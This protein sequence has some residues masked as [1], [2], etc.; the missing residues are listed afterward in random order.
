[1][2]QYP[3]SVVGFFD[4]SGFSSLARDLEQADKTRSEKAI[5]KRSASSYFAQHS[6]S[7]K[8][9]EELVRQLNETLSALIETIRA[10]GGDII[11]FAGDAI[12][13]VW[14]CDRDTM[15]CQ[16]LRATKC[17]VDCTMLKS[18]QSKLG[19]HVGIGC[20]E[21]V[22]AHVG[23]TFGR[24]EF[25]IAGEA[26]TQ[27]ALSEGHAGVNE[28]V[29]SPQ[30]CKVIHDSKLAKSIKGDSLEEGF[31]L[32]KHLAMN[33]P[34]QPPPPK[35]TLSTDPDIAKMAEGF[36][37]GPVRD[38]LKSGCSSSSSVGGL[39]KLTVIFF[40]LHDVVLPEKFDSESELKFLEQCQN[41]AKLVQDSAYHYW[42]T[43]RQFILDDKGFVAIVALGLP[44]YFHEDNAV[45]AVKVAKRLIEHHKVR[46]AAGICTG[47][48]FCG[49]VGST[50]RAEYSVAGSCI[51]LAARLM[52]RAKPGQIWCDTVT[53][54]EAESLGHI[55]FDQFPS[56][57]FKGFDQPVDIFG[58]SMA[59]ASSSNAT[60]PEAEE[61]LTKSVNVHTRL[62]RD[63]SAFSRRRKFTRAQS[64]RLN[65]N[66]V[67]METELIALS[68]ASFIGKDST[69]AVFLEGEAGSGKTRLVEWVLK[70][71][72]ARRVVLSAADSSEINT[73]FFV[74]R[75]ILQSVLAFTKSV[76][77]N[78][79]IPPTKKLPIGEKRIERPLAGRKRGFSNEADSVQSHQRRLSSEQLLANLLQHGHKR[80]Q[81]DMSKH[82]LGIASTVFD[83]QVPQVIDEGKNVSSELDE[84]EGEE[85]DALLVAKPPSG[86]GMS[87]MTAESL[88]TSGPSPKVMSF[89]YQSQGQYLPDQSAVLENLHESGKLK[90]KR[91]S[92]LHTILPTL[93]LPS[94]LENGQTTPT[95][96]AQLVFGSAQR[97]ASLGNRSMSGLN[98]SNINSSGQT[99][100]GSVALS[101]RTDGQSEAQAPMD[102]MLLLLEEFG[103]LVTTQIV[104]ENAH[105]MD[106][107][108]WELVKRLCEFSP[109]SWKGEDRIRI[110]VTYRPF[111]T[112]RDHP[113][114]MLVHGHPAASGNLSMARTS[115]DIQPTSNQALGGAVPGSPA[116]G[117]SDKLSSPPRVI[118]S[119]GARRRSLEARNPTSTV[120]VALESRSDSEDAEPRVVRVVISPFSQREAGVFLSNVHHT[121]MGPKLLSFLFRKS[122]GNPRALLDCFSALKD[123]EL[124][125]LDTATG[126]VEETTSLEDI[127]DMVFVIPPHLRAQLQQQFDNLHNREQ[128]ILKL[129]S[130]VGSTIPISLLKWLYKE[131]VTHMASPPNDASRDDSVSL[132]SDFNQ[133][134]L[135][136]RERDFLHPFLQTIPENARDSTDVGILSGRIG[137]D[138]EN[139]VF[140]S[141]FVQF[142]VYSQMLHT[143]RREVHGLVLDWYQVSP[144]HFR[145]REDPSLLGNH[146]VG[147][148]RH[149]TAFQCFQ[150]GLRR[151]VFKHEPVAKGVRL[152]QSCTD[153][154]DDPLTGFDT[155]QTIAHRVA[156]DVLMG[157]VCVQNE[158][159]DE[160]NE[161][162]QRAIEYAD[163]VSPRA[164][165]MSCFP[166]IWRRTRQRM[167]DGADKDPLVSVK[168]N[169][170]AEMSQKSRFAVELI[171]RIE[172]CRTVY[173]SR[174]ASMKAF[175][176]QQVG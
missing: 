66:L 8:G 94:E 105:F 85:A 103:I 133:G 106:K 150:E 107:Q 93:V 83:V 37:P 53:K 84:D 114:Q 102:M 158:E 126:T 135:E 144:P 68:R 20:G 28:V 146:A 153:L 71:S 72:G 159:W 82:Q 81:S 88:S 65:V 174:V 160:A 130:V 77:Q 22:A 73:P 87:F 80:S 175:N 31:F 98:S 52:A 139:W 30:A 40:K 164:E 110:V 36:V 26:C 162:L 74:W 123:Q 19:L 108:S 122:K 173:A 47:T 27:S 16:L 129:A 143:A 11:K 111:H 78:T 55:R 32:I 43:L 25:F 41:Q 138:D 125:N 46:A 152:W 128:H 3:E 7:G 59:T 169:L 140:E 134:L 171:R 90:G 38:A 35:Y 165:A 34:G 54:T 172:E 127:G 13:V 155:Q 29:V 101:D 137:C 132:D 49:V 89:M 118:M 124:I 116:T 57:P 96:S 100:V 136:L 56:M 79:L 104:I 161:Y 42:A 120:N 24:W 92:C 51:N 50:K 58:P 14:L 97:R 17:A 115:I 168:V 15:E 21:L 166:S 75:S 109:I 60:S 99:S 39:R 142:M 23:G 2:I 121:T 113:L 62:E 18:D 117:A 4:V 141:D 154:L 145:I 48:V 70:E 44:P 149:T 76:D 157:Q 5:K 91:L 64:T 131:R 61:S 163:Q 86:N 112:L 170:K 6:I 33:V 67:G 69:R 148:E 151:V 12:L 1:M 63:D 119:R 176:L 95:P 10:A 156:I 9:A 147:A 45:R 167:A